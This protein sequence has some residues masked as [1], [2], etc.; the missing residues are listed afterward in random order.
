MAN[1]LTILRLVLV[2]VLVAVIVVSHSAG[3][4]I[5][6]RGVACVVFVV[7]MITDYAD[8]KIA[9]SHGLVT[10]FGKIADPIADKALIGTA[11]ICLNWLG[12]APWWATVLIMFR[13]VG[14]TLLRLWLV[15]RYAE[16]GVIA[17]N[18]GGKLKTAVQGF[19]IAVLL[20]PWAE[21]GL[22]FVDSVGYWLLMGAVALTVL[23]GLDYLRQ[24]V[25][26]VRQ[27]SSSA[28]PSQ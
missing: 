6:W 15:R 7:G 13:E 21:F 22:S 24:V 18:R 9:R 19:A 2:P 4:G 10:S 20:I 11:L 17:A 5:V 16:A 8:G 12:L 26:L 23:T 27:L 3:A 14:I 1:Y 25:Q 28:K